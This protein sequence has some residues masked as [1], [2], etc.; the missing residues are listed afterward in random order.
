M[1]DPSLQDIPGYYLEPTPAQRKLEDFLRTT[2]SAVNLAQG[3][4]ASPNYQRNMQ[5]W[6][7]NADGTIDL[8]NNNTGLITYSKASVTHS[9]S[10]GGQYLVNVTVSA[11]KANRFG[12]IYGRIGGY[13]ATAFQLLN[14]H[15]CT[16]TID[17]GIGGSGL[18]ISNNTGATVTFTSWVAEVWGVYA[19]DLSFL[20]QAKFS[21]GGSGALTAVAAN[22]FN[23]GGF[24]TGE[25]ASSSSVTFANGA[26][27]RMHALFGSASASDTIT[28]T[29]YYV[30]SL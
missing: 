10:T 22:N 19:S 14:T 6:S 23:Q 29:D 28:M 3:S 7:L 30:Q 15:T 4:I 18:A 1:P 26:A 5:G 27:F 20:M 12:V 2:G 25:G 9:N 24:T 8:T 16:L 17:Y 21:A 11:S 13:G